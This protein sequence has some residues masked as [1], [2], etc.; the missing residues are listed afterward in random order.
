MSIDYQQGKSALK[1][2]HY[3]VNGGKSRVS[4]PFVISEDDI[5]MIK[6]IERLSQIDKIPGDNGRL[7]S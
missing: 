5:V 6:L 4:E 2:H 1:H 7:I 3:G